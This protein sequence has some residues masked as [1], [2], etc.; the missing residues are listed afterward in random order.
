M[1]VCTYFGKPKLNGKILK[2]R[3]MVYVQDLA[4]AYEPKSKDE[5]TWDS[6]DP[7]YTIGACDKGNLSTECAFAL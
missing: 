3:A 7:T 6:T 4:H 5:W 1:V 2:K